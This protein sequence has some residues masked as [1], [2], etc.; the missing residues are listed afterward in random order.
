M[1]RGETQVVDVVRASRFVEQDV[2]ISP[3]YG[4]LVEIIDHGAAIA[5]SIWE[6][7]V[8]GCIKTFVT[9]FGEK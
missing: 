2:P 9:A 5:L 8:F 7:V 1:N 6:V 4:S 3:G